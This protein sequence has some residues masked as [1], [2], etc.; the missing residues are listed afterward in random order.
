MALAG[1]EIRLRRGFPDNTSHCRGTTHARFGSEVEWNA[2][3]LVALLPA[4]RSLAWQEPPKT[5]R[6]ML[7]SRFLHCR[8]WFSKA[9]CCKQ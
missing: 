5:R 3:N 9:A 7:R 1:E 2:S 4:E 8:P 6:S